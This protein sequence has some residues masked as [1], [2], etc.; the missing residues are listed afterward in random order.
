MYVVWCDRVVYPRYRREVS[1]LFFPLIY[2]RP[3]LLCAGKTQRS[4]EKLRASLKFDFVA[5]CFLQALHIK[6]CCSGVD[7]S[8]FAYPVAPL[9]ILQLFSSVCTF[10]IIRAKQQRVL[11]VFY[12]HF[13]SF[14][15]AWPCKRRISGDLGH[16]HGLNIA[17]VFKFDVQVKQFPCSFVNVKTYRYQQD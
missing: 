7:R 8:L 11:P 12:I 17:D 4:A 6:L 14:G 10:A 1:R 2:H 3:L 9:V 5:V 16:C 15:S 13:H